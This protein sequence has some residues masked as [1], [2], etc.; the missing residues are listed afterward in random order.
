MNKVHFL[1]PVPLNVY[2]FPAS[3]FLFVC[4]LYFFLFNFI[5]FSWSYLRLSLLNLE[6]MCI[7]CKFVCEDRFG[8]RSVAILLMWIFSVLK[9]AEIWKKW[10]WHH[11]FIAAVQTCQSFFPSES[12]NQYKRNCL[13]LYSVFS[14]STFTHTH[15]RTDTYTHL[16]IFVVR[17]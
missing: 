10:S 17:L 7:G 14:L 11:R 3:V 2:C 4:L 12:H 16:Y 6:A 5:S 15:R 9:I 8:E 13:F 1:L